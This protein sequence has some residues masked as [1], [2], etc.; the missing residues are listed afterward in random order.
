MRILL[1]NADMSYPGGTQA[2]TRSLYMSLTRD[3]EVSLFVDRGQVPPDFRPFDPK[4]QYDL[5][6]VN[7]GT[8]L[9]ALRRAKIKTRIMTCHGVVPAE[10]WARAGADAYVAVSEYVAA[11]IPWPSRIIRNPIDTSRFYDAGP[12][13]DPPRRAVF[14]SNRQGRALE[15]I[16]EGCRRAGVELEVVGGSN[17]TLHPEHAIAKADVVF[18]IGRSA[19][20]GLAMGRR[21]IAFDH[22]GC[23]GLIS[24]ENISSLRKDN[25]GGY[26]DSWWPSGEEIADLVTSASALS[27]RDYVETAHSPA[28]VVNEY[29]LI[30]DQLAFLPRLMS[31]LVRRG[32][33]FLMSARVTAAVSEIRLGRLRNALSAIREE[34]RRPTPSP[35]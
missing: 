32:P 20:E 19:L 17:S 28:T 10:E 21:V 15:I 25:F 12:T 2:W 7:H 3:H 27:M 34:P 30:A 14:L 4:V 16:T 13:S 24:P 9:T 31:T 8:C 26:I 22:L 5:A 18:G 23:K 6:L 1:T 29:L 35:M 11:H 33:R